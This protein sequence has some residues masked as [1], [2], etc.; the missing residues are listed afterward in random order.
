MAFYY[1]LRSVFVSILLG[2]IWFDINDG[3]VES[4]VLLASV[5]YVYIVASLADLFDGTIECHD[6]MM[7]PCM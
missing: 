1:Q 6:M 5:A 3:E 4:R 7:R 2:C